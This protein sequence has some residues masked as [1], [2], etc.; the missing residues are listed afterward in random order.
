MTISAHTAKAEK[1]EF[2]F[3]IALVCCFIGCSKGGDNGNTTPAAKPAI[4]SDTA[5]WTMTTVVDGFNDLQ[6][7]AIDSSGNLYLT[8]DTLVAKITP[9][10]VVSTFAP[11][12][13]HPVGIAA[14]NNGNIYVADLVHSDSFDPPNSKTILYRCN[15]AGTRDSFSQLNTI[16]PSLTVDHA[17]NL[18]VLAVDTKYYS[19]DVIKFSPAGIAAPWATNF[20]DG[21]VYGLSRDPGGTL[22]TSSTT[23]TIHQAPINFV[24][25]DPTGKPGAFIPSGDISNIE[26]LNLCVSNGAVYMV[27]YTGGNIYQFNIATGQG[28]LIAAGLLNPSGIVVDRTGAVFV[29]VSHTRDSRDGKIVKLTRK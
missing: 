29:T 6:R 19:S 20:G 18:Y 10:G 27:S 8:C 17:G 9:G 1:Y 15:S 13:I 2:P 22:Y 3:W 21:Q 24:T 14:D 4:P 11:G 26:L 7:L 5:S 28:A 16:A 25:I 12:L 23:R